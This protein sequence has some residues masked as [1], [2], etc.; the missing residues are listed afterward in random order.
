MLHDKICCHYDLLWKEKLQLQHEK[1]YLSFYLKLFII[2]EYKV[3]KYHG[4]LY[5]FNQGA[6]TEKKSAKLDLI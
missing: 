1:G 2:W 3:V 6:F 4:W 5:L